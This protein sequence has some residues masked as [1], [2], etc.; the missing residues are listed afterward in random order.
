MNE[1]KLTRHFSFILSYIFFSK[2]K[3]CLAFPSALRQS[4]EFENQNHWGNEYDAAK[5]NDDKKFME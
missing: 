5:K 2:Q 4:T 1:M 3:H